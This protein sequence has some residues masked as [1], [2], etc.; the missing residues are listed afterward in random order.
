[1]FYGKY[2]Y[3]YAWTVSASFLS[4]KTPALLV[5]LFLMFFLSL[6]LYL[7]RN[8]LLFTTKKKTKKSSEEFFKFSSV[9]YLL[10]Y[11]LI[12]F[13]NCS[14]ILVINIFYIIVNLNAN[15]TKITITQISFGVFKIIWNGF[16]TPKMYEFANSNNIDNNNN[17]NNNNKKKNTINV[18]FNNRDGSNGINNSNNN[19]N[20]NLNGYNNINNE[21][22]NKF[23]ETFFYYIVIVWNNI[24]TPVIVTLIVSPSCFYYTIRP[25]PKVSI[26]FTVNGLCIGSPTNAGQKCNRSVPAVAIFLGPFIYNY[27]CSLSILQS[28][29]AAYVYLFAIK[30]FLIPISLIALKGFQ[31]YIYSN[32]ENWHSLYNFISIILPNILKPIQALH[33]EFS[34]T[35][36][37]AIIVDNYNNYSLR[38][39]AFDYNNKINKFSKGT[40]NSSNSKKMIDYS[41]INKFE[42]ITLDETIIFNS[43]NCN[44]IQETKNTEENNDIEQKVDLNISET[45]NNV[46][47]SN[48]NCL[49]NNVTN[50]NLVIK[51]YNKEKNSFYNFFWKNTD[52]KMIFNY[53][54]FISDT[55]FGLCILVTFGT[56]FPPMAIEICIAMISN[57]Y[58]NQVAIARLL[59]EAEEQN[60]LECKQILIQNL[61]ETM[62]MLK[63]I[64]V[65]LVPFAFCF[66]VF[67]IFDILDTTDGLSEFF[68]FSV[69]ICL[70][71]VICWFVFV[72]VFNFLYINKKL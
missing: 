60:V 10:K 58:F 72:K 18:D 34:R 16:V 46:V 71:I 57:T 30:S 41:E 31:S 5:V 28:Y 45:K 15:Q 38:Y 51:N 37:D 63:Y 22:S 62:K 27:Q 23:M 55:I 7:L 59:I 35:N 42:S 9:K 54:E 11:V 56:V 61:E 29:A 2:K 26:D 1:M 70:C 49:N 44:N 47:T 4:G 50:H 67:F 68:G 32:H 65:L 69:S 21:N 6:I 12:I 24:V 53:K 52:I 25:P 36:D 19:N 40:L 14:I 8:D 20:N 13:L 33:K 64:G 48:E 17:T 43:D 66:Y 3:G 39:K